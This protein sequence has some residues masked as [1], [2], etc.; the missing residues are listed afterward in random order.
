VLRCAATNSRSL[1]GVESAQGPPNACPGAALYA[2][3]VEGVGQLACGYHVSL[4]PGAPATAE[5]LV[6]QMGN[7]PGV[8]REFTRRPRGAWLTPLVVGHLYCDRLAARVTTRPV[9]AFHRN[10]INATGARSR[11]LGSNHHHIVA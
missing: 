8:A 2:A 9:G 10:C 5:D 1:I 6:D 7:A 4:M 3:I 11:T